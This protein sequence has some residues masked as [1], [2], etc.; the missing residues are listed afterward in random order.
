M[1]AAARVGDKTAHGQ[2]LT[3]LPGGGS[4]NVFIEG[5]PAWRAKIDW[6]VCPLSDGTK[7][8]GS[9]IVPLGSI[10]VLINKCPAARQGD[11]IKEVGQPI[12]PNIIT[13][14]SAKVSIGG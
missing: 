12:V 5:R 2:V 1:P 14:G 4:P 6:H 7:P 8:H 9:G 3:P 11:T 10:K 13:E